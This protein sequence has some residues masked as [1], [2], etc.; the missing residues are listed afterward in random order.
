MYCGSIRISRSPALPAASQ[1]NGKLLANSAAAG[2]NL[3]RK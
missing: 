1:R 3:P 2:L